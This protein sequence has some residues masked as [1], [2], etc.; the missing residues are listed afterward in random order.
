MK[1]PTKVQLPI[2]LRRVSAARS[3]ALNPALCWLC[4]VTF[5]SLMGSEYGGHPD[6]RSFHLR[7]WIGGYCR[8]RVCAPMQKC[9][10]EAL[11]TRR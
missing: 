2:P 7:F 6:A 8:G 1:T 4:Q 3:P 10:L 5:R 11:A 9:F